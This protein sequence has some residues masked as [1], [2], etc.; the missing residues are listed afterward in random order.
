MTTGDRKYLRFSMWAQMDGRR[1]KQQQNIP[2][3]KV[4]TTDD[5]KYLRFSTWAQMDGRR[6]QQQ[7]NIPMS[8]D[9][10]RS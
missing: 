7:Q 9:N 1:Q 6:Q 4:M 10:R 3:G 2:N 5:H 8:N